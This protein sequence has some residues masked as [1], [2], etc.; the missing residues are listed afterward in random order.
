VNLI[1]VQGIGVLVTLIAAVLAAWNAHSANRSQSDVQ[2]RTVS[3]EELEKALTFTGEQ[4]EDLRGET[5]RLQG[6]VRDLENAHQECE[7]EKRRLDREI[8]ELRR[9]A[10]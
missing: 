2:H 6:K 3:L 9:G 10:R 1:W 8:M 5:T 4:L 7:Q